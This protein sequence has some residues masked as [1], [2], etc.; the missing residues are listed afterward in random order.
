M[1]NDIIKEHAYLVSR[2]VRSLALVDV[3]EAN[4][5]LAILKAYNDMEFALLNISPGSGNPVVPFAV[6]RKDGDLVDVGFA[7][8]SWVV[9]YV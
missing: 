9:D 3:V 8:R 5:P 6:M 2:G 4:D 1:K 7:A